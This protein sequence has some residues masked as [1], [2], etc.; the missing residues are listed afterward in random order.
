MSDSF[1]PRFVLA[2]LATWRITHLFVRE[3]GPGDV[4]AGMR[5]RLGRGLFGQLMDCFYCSSLWIAAPLALVMSSTWGEAG[6]SWPALSGAAC[7]FERI[8][9]QAP[10]VIEPLHKGDD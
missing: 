8:G 10:L 2:A 4:I 5:A 9:P 3:D 6:L 7:L 1:W